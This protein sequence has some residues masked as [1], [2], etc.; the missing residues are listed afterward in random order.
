MINTVKK[1][2]YKNTFPNDS[3]ISTRIVR[4]EERVKL[5]KR[6]TKITKNYEV[7]DRLNKLI[8]DKVVRIEGDMIFG[9]YLSDIKKSTKVCTTQIQIMFLNDVIE[10]T[11]FIHI[12]NE[13]YRFSF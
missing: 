4:V 8:T 7:L 12:W 11:T 9:T 3:Y 2:T 1:T 5:I 13:E 6:I 10:I